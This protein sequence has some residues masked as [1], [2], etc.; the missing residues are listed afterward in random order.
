MHLNQL[1]GIFGRKKELIE[2]INIYKKDLPKYLLHK[3][4]RNIIVINEGSI[5]IQKN[6]DS[7]IINE[8]NTKFNLN[9]NSQYSE[10]KNNVAIAAAVT[11]YARIHMIPFKLN[12]DIYYTDTIFTSKPLNS[13]L[14]SKIELKK[15]IL[16]IRVLPDLNWDPS[17]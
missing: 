8:L 14:I 5:L 6:I 16:F 11:A 4:I 1:Y 15:I 17:N 7:N 3:I 12:E 9:Y 2:T 13:N 10:V